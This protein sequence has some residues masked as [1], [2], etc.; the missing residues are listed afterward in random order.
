MGGLFHLQMNS[1]EQSLVV[2]VTWRYAKL[3]CAHLENNQ[4]VWPHR[5]PFDVTPPE[6][7]EE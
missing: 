1:R 2:D 3:E 4:N 7:T 5:N 6:E